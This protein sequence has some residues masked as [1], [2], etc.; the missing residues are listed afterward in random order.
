MKIND[1]LRTMASEV[2]NNR[3]L[4]WRDFYYTLKYLGVKRYDNLASDIENFYKEFLVSLNNS[5]VK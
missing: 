2:A 5:L 3:E 4:D 1:F